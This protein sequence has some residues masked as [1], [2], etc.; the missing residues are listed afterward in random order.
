[1]RRQ[2]CP[3]M[4]CIKRGCRGCAEK[5]VSGYKDIPGCA[6]A[7]YSVSGRR[8]LRMAYVRPELI[9][10]EIRRDAAEQESRRYKTAQS[11]RVYSIVSRMFLSEQLQATLDMWCA[12]MTF[13]RIGR[14]FGVSKNMARL[15][16]VKA[17][18][19][20]RTCAAKV[21]WIAEEIKDCVC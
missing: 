15:R 18:A 13:E 19:R 17:I 9:S 7:G 14:C 1:M 8:V 16:F 5:M 10:A 6:M 3:L 20:I 21:P 11:K 4:K 2:A 12:G